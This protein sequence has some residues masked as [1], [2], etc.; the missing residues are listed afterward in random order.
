M[1]LSLDPSLH[2]HVVVVVLLQAGG[3]VFCT[4][5]LTISGS[6]FNS[7][8]APTGSA[9]QVSRKEYSTNEGGFGEVYSREHYTN[10]E[11][12]AAFGSTSG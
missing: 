5:E 3:A 7:N 9:I 1:P 10:E 4:G 2:F 8:T 6:S 12:N 11:A